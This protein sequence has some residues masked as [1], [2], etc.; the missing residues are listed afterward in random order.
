M[1]WEYNGTRDHRQ[2]SSCQNDIKIYREKKRTSYDYM[3]SSNVEKN[4]KIFPEVVE[5]SLPL[6]LSPSTKK[7]RKKNRLCRSTFTFHKTGPID[8]YTGVRQAQ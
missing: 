4:V 3:L 7:E 8:M 1:F 2:C 6:S 5:F